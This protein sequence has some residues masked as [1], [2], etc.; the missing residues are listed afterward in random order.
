MWKPAERIIHKP[1]PGAVP[2]REDAAECPVVQAR[3]TLGPVQLEQRTWVPAMVPW[4]ASEDG[5]ITP[6]VLD[7]YER[8][9]AGRP[10]GLVVEA[11]GIRDVPSGPLLRIGDDRYIPGL[12]DLVDRVRTASSGTDTAVHS[13]YRFSGDQTAPRPG[14]IS[15]RGFWRSQTGIATSSGAH[16]TVRTPRFAKN[17]HHLA[18]A[19]LEAVLTE[20]E[21]ESL[22]MG[23]RE[24]VTDVH[25]D[26][27]RAL[28]DVLPGLFADAAEPRARGRFRWC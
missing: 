9:A 24:R 27:I 25:L 11:T 28:P 1:D 21:L 10:G 17:W 12:K 26:H 13:A 23:Y 4:R 6:D 18:P 15:S 3:S 16:R 8:F 22:Q 14:Q 7:W 19:E 20:R 5:D 2:S